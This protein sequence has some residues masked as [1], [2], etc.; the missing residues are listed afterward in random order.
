MALAPSN[1]LF[2][3]WGT[4]LVFNSCG[5]LSFLGENASVSCDRG[6]RGGKSSINLFIILLEHAEIVED[7][8]RHEVGKI[9]RLFGS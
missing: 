6:L 9:M 5:V 1:C 4:V 2:Y 8:S 3:L 7:C